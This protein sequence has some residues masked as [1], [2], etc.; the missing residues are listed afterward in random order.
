MV[1]DRRDRPRAGAAGTGRRGGAD[2]RG[3]RHHAGP[4]AAGGG[5]A[6]AE[7]PV[8]VTDDVG[9]TV[10]SVPAVGG[11]ER[12]GLARGAVALLDVAQS[13]ADL[14]DGIGAPVGAGGGHLGAGQGLRDAVRPR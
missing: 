1:R 13:P 3:P 10:D 8:G 4:A 7:R 5:D 6:A 9:V 14:G 2:R 11:L 12:P